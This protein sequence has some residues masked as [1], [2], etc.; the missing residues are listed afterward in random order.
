MD[1]LGSTHTSM[2][3]VE[4]VFET[5][6]DVME[7]K[8][9]FGH[10]QVDLH[11]DAILFGNRGPNVIE[12]CEKTHVDYCVSGQPE[13]WMTDGP[14]ITIRTG[15]SYTIPPGH[16]ARVV[17]NERSSASTWPALRRT[18]SAVHGYAVR[19]LTE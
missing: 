11:G 12:Y 5:V 10:M 13:T 1:L 2:Q 19:R 18:Q 9:S 15:E 16:N 4:N 17:G 6:V 8:H 7:A 14:R 3:G